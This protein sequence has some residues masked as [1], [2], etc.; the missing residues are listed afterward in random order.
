M[1]PSVAGLYMV[2]MLF[3]NGYQSFVYIRLHGNKPFYPD[4]NATFRFLI[5]PKISV[6]REESMN[7]D[8]NDLCA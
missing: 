1:I 7:V 4:L 3:S 2:E 6:L 8:P 5:L